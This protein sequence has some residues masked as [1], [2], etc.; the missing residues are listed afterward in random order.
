MFSQNSAFK[1]FKEIDKNERTQTQ[2]PKNKCVLLKV[3][4]EV[5]LGN[6]LKRKYI[7]TICQT[8][9]FGKHKNVHL[10]WCVSRVGGLRYVKVTVKLGPSVKSEGP[11]IR[12]VQLCTHTCPNTH[13]CLHISCE[14]ATWGSLALGISVCVWMWDW[15]EGLAGG[16]RRRFQ[17]DT[18][19]LEA[20]VAQTPAASSNTQPTHQSLPRLIN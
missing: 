16:R 4:I 3:R 10:W 2:L 13:I 12:R 9:A 7:N 18:H 6:R 11:F 1:C 8:R 17:V 20:C 19:M 15:P 14:G 5:F